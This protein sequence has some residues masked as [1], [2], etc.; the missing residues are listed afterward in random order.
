MVIAGEVPLALD[1]YNYMPEQAKRKG[2]PI[3]WFVLEPAVARSNAIGVARRAPHPNAALLFYEY[4][5][6]EEGQRV[7]VK[8]DYVPS[9]TKVA[10][11]LKGVKI[12]QT[13]P[14]R[15]LDESD[16][17]KDLF[18]KIVLNPSRN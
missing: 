4:M 10:S 16:K 5:L 7:L 13:D 6:G 8:M 11:P 9:N 12:L 14:I 3:D 18:E 15:T 2:A 17:W 1:I